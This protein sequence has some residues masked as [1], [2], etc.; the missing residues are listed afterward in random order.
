MSNKSCPNCGSPIT[1]SELTCKA[2]G[3]IIAEEKEIKL[4]DEYILKIE[5]NIQNLNSIT[6]V[7]TFDVMLIFFTVFFIYPSGLFYFPF[8]IE[9]ILVF[10][11][12]R[13][14]RAK[15]L[16]FNYF[17][18][19][20]RFDRDYVEFSSLYP[21]NK[22]LQEL[23]SAFDAKIATNLNSL[24]KNIIL[25]SVFTGLLFIVTT[26]IFFS[27]KSVNK[28]TYFSNEILN[29][30]TSKISVI[31]D[32]TELFALFSNNFYIDFYANDIYD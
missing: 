32:S 7:K 31:A 4:I 24:K 9:L 21:K 5:Q 27:H 23:K 28:E 1:D 29:V 17:S 15:N 12:I 11:F 3:F 20:D 26:T 16:T 19:K 13:N 2:C 8:F 22:K 30:K 18:A 6:T 14:K 25:S 10:L